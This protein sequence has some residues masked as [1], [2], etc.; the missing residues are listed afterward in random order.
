MARSVQT[1]EYSYPYRG[2]VLGRR[3]IVPSTMLSDYREIESNIERSVRDV[4]GTE[5]GDSGDPRVRSRHVVQAA[6]SV[7]SLLRQVYHALDSSSA[8]PPFVDLLAPG[9]H[10]KH[11]CTGLLM[12]PRSQVSPSQNTPFT[13]A[14]IVAVPYTLQGYKNTAEAHALFSIHISFRNKLHSQ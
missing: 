3:L 11:E 13:S 10:W 8:S 6:N 1:Q 7:H 2:E 4:V 9:F 12:Q 14:Q 5:L